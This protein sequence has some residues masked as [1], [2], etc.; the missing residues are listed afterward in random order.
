MII[1]CVSFW[2]R[3]TDWNCK[4]DHE[5]VLVNVL[6]ILARWLKEM[7]FFDRIHRKQHNKWINWC[8]SVLCDLQTRLMNWIWTMNWDWWTWLYDKTIATNQCEQLCWSNEYDWPLL[9]LIYELYSV[10][11]FT[12]FA[13]HWIC[14]TNVLLGIYR[15]KAFIRLPVRD[16][17]RKEAQRLWI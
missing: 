12:A 2:D 1:N 5:A 16:I 8:N 17:Q 7:T 3:W 15:R 10:C 6:L 13:D 4:C 14:L 11:K 9:L